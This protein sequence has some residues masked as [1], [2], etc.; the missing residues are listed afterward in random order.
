MIT[1][2]DNTYVECI[3]F[4]DMGD[5]SFMGCLFHEGGGRWQVKY[6]FREHRDNKVFDSNDE[7]AWYVMKPRA[8]LVSREQA[9]RELFEM[10]NTTVGELAKRARTEVELVMVRGDGPAA[11]RAISAQRWGHVRMESKGSA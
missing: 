3:W 2:T 11:F 8:G 1:L 5:Q 9:Q 7:R 6:R 10:M 4:V